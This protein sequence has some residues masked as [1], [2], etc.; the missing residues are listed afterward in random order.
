VITLGQT[1]T[2]CGRTIF[3]VPDDL[4]TPVLECDGALYAMD[5][6][7]HGTLVTCPRC[8]PGTHHRPA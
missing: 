2:Y 8:L 1:R 3:A 4:T 5:V 7:S 6:T